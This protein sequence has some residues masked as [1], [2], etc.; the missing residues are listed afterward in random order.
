MNNLSQI[1]FNNSELYENKTLFGFKI[2]NNWEHLS[3]KQSA[4]LVLNISSALYDLGVKKMTKY[5]LSLKIA[6]SGVS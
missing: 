6:I 4:D 2:N 5:L 1:F 3:W